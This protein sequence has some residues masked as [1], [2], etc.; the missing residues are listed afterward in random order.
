MTSKSKFTYLIAL[1]LSTL[2][3]LLPSL[4][5]QASNGMT[6]AGAA[7]AVNPHQAD[8][9]PVGN[10]ASND[11]LHFT[12]IAV[13]E[14]PGNQQVAD[15]LQGET[16][17]LQAGK[18]YALKVAYKIPKELQFMPTYLKL[19]FGDGLYLKTLPGATFNVGKID[20]TGFEELVK[21]PTG[22]GTSPYNY[23]P[24]DSEKAKNGELVYKSKDSLLDVE[25]TDICFALD[26]AYLNE[27]TEQILANLINCAL[28]DSAENT[29]TVYD[30]KSFS[31]KSTE[32][33]SYGFWNEQSTEVVSKGGTTN[34]LQSSTAGGG[35]ALTREHS[36]TT[37][38]LVYPKD[39]E[40]VGLEETALYKKNGT[41]KET[42]EDGDNKITT[43]EWE[44]AGSYSGGATFKPHLK[45]PADSQRANGSSFTVSIQ[46]FKKT[47]YEDNPAVGRTSKNN[48][49]NLTITIIDGSTPEK[50]LTHALVDT[51][52]NWAKQK[53]TSYNAR[54]GML[55]VKN[56]LS[57]PTFPKTLELSI[58]ED[59]VAIVRGVTIPYH[60][61]INYGQ[62]AWTSAS[63]KSGTVTADVLK[64]SKDGVGALLTNTALGLDIDDSIKSI[65]V[66]LGSI[67]ANYDGIHPYED[68]LETW[69]ANNKYVYEEAY[70]WSYAPCAIFGTWQK[71]KDADIKTTVKLYTTNETAKPTEIHKLIG[72]SA[73][74]KILNGVGQIDKKQVVGGET[75]KITGKINDAN[76]DWNSMQEPVIYMFM[77]E[78]FSYSDLTV[79]N[80]KLGTAEFVGNYTLQ[81][82]RSL[83]VWK[84]ELDIGEETRGQYQPDFSIKS[85][86]LA[87]TIKTD[88]KAKVATYH[89][90]DFIGI[91]TKD[92]VK[93]GAELKYEH[94]DKANWKVEQYLKAVDEKVNG[95]KALVSL[96]EKQGVAIKQAYEVT[97][98]AEQFLTKSGETFTYDPSSEDSKKKTTPLLDNGETTVMHIAVRNNT[99]HSVD[100]VS[101]FVPL[102]Q[103][104]VDLGKAFMPE[105]KL[106]VPLTCDKVEVSKNF[107]VKYLKIKAGKIY[108][109]NTSPQVGDYKE[110]SDIKEANVLL[111]SSTQALGKGDGGKIDI[112]YKAEN[113][114]EK[115]NNL[116]SVIT[117]V[118]DYDINGNTSVLSKEATAVGC[119]TAATEPEPKPSEPKP[120]EP[121]PTEPKPSEPTPTEPQ[122]VPTETEPLTP[123]II[124][125]P[126]PAE[127]VEIDLTKRGTVSKTGEIAV[128]NLGYLM[129]TLACVAYIIYKRKK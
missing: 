49:A 120:T 64:K 88:K 105:G 95:G 98:Q 3:G 83:K 53:Y 63:G 119:N 112:T 107:T 56:E 29:A 9:A 43:F 87:C 42:R 100:H 75:F 73:S 113:L 118:L 111:L 109:L 16:P 30:N 78:G 8:L 96:S 47:V 122:P 38:E 69:Q 114:T 15:L 46:N 76:W 74:P 116:K 25:N 129:S 58:D 126:S 50:T 20:S 4:A 40:L 123:A 93:I 110:V 127:P 11:K 35:T 80:A 82:G 71:G 128:G 36:K 108:A 79:E 10:T 48:K 90:N 33:Y 115:Y 62:I 31:V 91:T 125:P 106:G 89:I 18:T 24:A 37:V 5:V 81:D 51:A 27:S 57:I 85:M 52:S 84:H 26:E 117:P 59:N 60:K 23:P 19:Y 7:N 21:A 66:D 61:D 1:F 39:I 67:P 34:T 32:S 124:V 72:R 2:L 54:I 6:E 86:N 97:A 77:P 121:K 17:K 45:V 12:K 14:Y 101:L 41:I 70:Y 22:T 55:L 94:W 13:L 44:E 28:S 65:K 92:F 68:L 102:M 99:E 103:D 104:K